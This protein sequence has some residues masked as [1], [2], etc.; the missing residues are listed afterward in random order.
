M[1]LLKYNNIGI[2]ALA[3]CV[4]K[5]KQSNLDLIPYFGEKEIYNIIK[6]TGIKERRVTDSKTTAS[7]LCFAAAE[8]LFNDFDINR[9]SIDILI[10][11]SQDNDY[12]IPATAP[13]LQH[14]LGLPK[15]TAAFDLSLSCSG[16]I[17]AL[18]VAFSLVSQDSIHKVLLLDGET[19]SKLVNLKDKSNAPLYG[20][21]GTATLI[22][23][24][25][26]G[27]SVFSL[28]SDG[29][30]IDALKIDAGG[31][32]NPTDENNIREQTSA[33]GDIRT[34]HQLF[35]DGKKVFDFSLLHVPDDIAKIL[36][37]TGNTPESVDLLI[38]HQANKFI[39]DYFRKRLKFPEEKV[40]YSIDR[41]GNT[42]SASIPLT[43][44]TE[45]KSIKR[46]NVIL[47][48]F[49]AGLSWAT[50]HLSLKNCRMCDLLEI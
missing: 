49:G 28:N 4:P 43:I 26:F 27:S 3:A 37:I 8:K 1:A 31:A 24:G 21:A 39:T 41:F 13:G 22:E 16:Y 19:F 23:K 6:S 29:S 7:D 42:S 10:F 2:S 12:K 11:L 17:Y 50:A 14:R 15:T 18:S 5:Q 32:R 47:S 46:D 35:M 36:D 44:V 25:D 40:P 45:T 48:G 38:L 30:G 33:N 20:D 9:N 34:P